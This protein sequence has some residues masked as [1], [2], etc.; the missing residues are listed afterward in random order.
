MSTKQLFIYLYVVPVTHIQVTDHQLL[1]LTEIPAQ[2]C[3]APIEDQIIRAIQLLPLLDP[4]EQVQVVVQQI[5]P[6]A[7][8]PVQNARLQM[9]NHLEVQE[10][11]ADFQL[12]LVAKVQAADQFIQ[13]VTPHAVRAA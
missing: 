8:R 3:P 10:V 2:V 5:Q 9:A 1:L 11:P 13:A 6:D 12:A 4:V 7:P